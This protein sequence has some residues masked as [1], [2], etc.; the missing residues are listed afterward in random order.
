[1][2]LCYGYSECFQKK[3]SLIP[4]KRRAVF[5]FFSSTEPS[6]LTHQN[7]NH[8][9]L[10]EFLR[11]PGLQWETREL[12]KEIGVHC[13]WSYYYFMIIGFYILEVLAFYVL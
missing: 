3:L 2:F 1:M 5:F 9:S 10:V 8:L 6:L 13:A 12:L 7:Y 4:L 11:L